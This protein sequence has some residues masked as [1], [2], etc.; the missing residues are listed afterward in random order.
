MK[1]KLSNTGCPGDGQRGYAVLSLVILLVIMTI[2]LAASTA[3]LNWLQREVKLVDK[4]QNERL[5]LISR[6]AQSSGTSTNQPAK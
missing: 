2:L 5:T 4:R 3:T 1:T 6:A